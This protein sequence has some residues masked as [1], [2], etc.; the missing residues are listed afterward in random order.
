[1][2]KT[3]D[4]IH[5]N[6]KV[7][8]IINPILTSNLSKNNNFISSEEIKSDSSKHLKKL[9]HYIKTKITGEKKN[10]KIFPSSHFVTEQ[11]KLD[12]ES[13]LKEENDKFRLSLFDIVNP[14]IC[15]N[16]KENYKRFIQ[17]TKFIENQL[18]IRN[19]IFKIN[20]VD[21]LTFILTGY[22]YRKL[23]ESCPNPFNN[24]N[25]PEQSFDSYS[26][27][28]LEDFDNFLI[29]NIKNITNK[30]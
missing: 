25:M 22:K 17:I 3:K 13:A 4:C 10:G 5:L 30:I 2:R 11:I 21:K 20:M 15:F 26:A 12:F 9:N 28:D 6:I 8:N 18:E 24:N 1:M 27:G 19:I 23:L 29:N 14:F 16:E 7:S